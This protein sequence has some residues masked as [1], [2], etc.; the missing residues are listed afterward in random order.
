MGVSGTDVTQGQC[1]RWTDGSPLDDSRRICA[2]FRTADYED[3]VLLRSITSDI[4]HENQ[5]FVLPNLFLRE[6]SESST[7]RAAGL[8]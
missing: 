8:T 3:G 1:A 4:L 5:F 7:L 2:P 6:L